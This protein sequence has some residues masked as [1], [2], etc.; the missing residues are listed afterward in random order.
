MVHRPPLG[1]FSLDE[2]L[3]DED[4][5]MVPHGYLSDD[6]GGMTGSDDEN[7]EPETEQQKQ[8]RREQRL[9]RAQAKLE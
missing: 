9:A 1:L 4:G 5:W 8:A 6:E 7:D 2:D 3:N